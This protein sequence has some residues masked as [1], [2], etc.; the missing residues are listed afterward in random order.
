[1]R[2]RSIGSTILAL[3]FAGA[4]TALGQVTTTGTIQV[5]LEDPQGGRLPGVTATATASD[6][7]TT[8]TAVSDAEGVATLEALAPS[9]LYTVKASLSGFLDFSRDTILVRSG[10]TTTLHVQL[11]LSTVTEQ[12]TVTGQTTPVVDVTRAISGQD[13][14]LQLTEQLPTGRS[15]QSYLQLVPG[16]A[17][18]SQI[19]AGNPASRSGINFKENSATSDNIGG[20]TDNVYYLEGI[21]VTDPVTGTFGANLN[22]EIIQEQKVITG[23]IPAEYV[24]A[25]GL[26][27]TVITKSGSNSY[28]GSYNYFF[29]NDG[30]VSANV[31]SPGDAFSTKD[32]AFTIGGP[33]VKNSLWGFGSFRYLKTAQDV[34][35]SDT[36]QFLRRAETTG[37]QGFAKG[38]W[39]PRQSD[40][41]T[42]TFLNDPQTRSADTDASVANS[43]VRRRET[44]RQ[45]LLGGLQQDLELAAGRRRLE[46]SRRGDLRLL[47]GH[48]QV[49][50]HGGVHDQRRAHPGRRAAWRIRT[51]LPR[52]AADLAGARQGAVPVEPPQLQGRPRMDAARG[53]PEPELH[54]SGSRAVHVDHES[55]PGD[56][57]DHGRRHLDVN[58]LVDPPVPDVDRVGLQ[59]VD[60]E[61]Q[62][63][64]EP[65][66]VLHRVRHQPRRDDQRGRN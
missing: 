53:S 59:R 6:T 39:V 65:R 16:V 30:F 47:G 26:I 4:G 42:F 35:A 48:G 31:H 7:V 38:T 1:M 20:S 19:S 61:D 49:A 32:T 43:R 36:L 29:S 12:V 13:I 55:L 54:R 17:P 10:Q 41:V 63:P 52:D 44:G 58:R 40:M 5:V 18:D 34:S 37:K 51:E 15:Y 66:G 28:S 24:G 9:A 45:P 25:S 62:H 27:S 11:L 46:L 2:L 23:G 14:T 64:A 33:A 3:I 57:R 56:R 22:T 50:Q 60:C 21:N 8:R